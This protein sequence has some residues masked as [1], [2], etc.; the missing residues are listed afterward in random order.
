MTHAP[1]GPRRDEPALRPGLHAAPPSEIRCRLDRPRVLSRDE[2]RRLDRLAVEAL[3]LPSILLM[4]NAAAGA[5]EVAIERLP[6]A[7]RV[8][9]LAG[10][11]HNGGDGLAMARH[12]HLRGVPVAVLLLADPARL[13]PDSAANLQALRA[14]AVE[15]EIVPSPAGATP[16]DVL[17]AIARHRPH[18]AV[19][20]LLGTGL[21][22]PIDPSAGDPTASG[23]AALNAARGQRLCDDILALDL[24]SGL[25]ADT[26]ATLGDAVT[27]DATVTFAA[28][29]RGFFTL[30]AQRRLGEVTLVAIGVP[31]EITE[32]FGEPYLP[33]HR[34]HARDD[35]DHPPLPPTSPAAPG[36]RARGGPAPTDR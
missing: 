29:K 34:A 21:S 3:G 2:L 4:E 12:L 25:D 6:P 31:P 1:D 18:L 35:R 14:T 33:A 5:A 13:P 26:G 28:L 11:G 32:R 30:D 9:V 15:I 36:R 8:L 7:G 22:R 17:P 16:V 24:P 23:I 27:A 10:P 20:A 19:D